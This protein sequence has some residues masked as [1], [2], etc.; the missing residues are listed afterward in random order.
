MTMAPVDA[1]T[2]QERALRQDERIVTLRLDPLREGIP[3]LNVASRLIAARSTLTVNGA[4]TVTIELFDPEWLIEESGLLDMDRHADLPAIRIHL[5]GL[6]YRLV[7]VSRRRW[8]VCELTF[9]DEVVSL[10]RRHNRPLSASRGSMTRGEFIETMVREVKARRIVFYSP[11]KGTRQPRARP[12]YPDARP[13]SGET[14]F[15]DGTTFKIKGVRADAEQMRH[16]ATSLKVAGQENAPERPVLAMLVAGIGESSFRA[17][18][19]QAGSA[20]GGVFQGDVRGGKFKLNDTEG[21]ARCFLKGG[22]GFQADGAIAA[23]RAHPDW[24]PGEIA[25]HVEGSLSNFPSLQAGIRHYQQ[26]IDEAR[27]ILSKWG[28]ADGADTDTVLRTRSYQFRRGKP[29]ERE[30]SWQAATR[31]AR[32]VRWRLFAFAGE[33]WFVSDDY[34]ISKPAALVLDGH[35]APGLLEP[36]TYDRDNGKTIQQTV[37]RV[38]ANRWS[39]RPGEVVRLEGMGPLNSR[40]IIGEVEQDLFNATETTVTLTKARAPRKEPAPALIERDVEEAAD[41]TG[42]GGGGGPIPGLAGAQRAVRWA[43]SM[44]GHYVEV[45]FTN[46]GPELDRLQSSFG[47]RAQPWCAMFATTAVQHGGVTRDCRTAAVNQVYV[48]ARAGSHGYLGLRATPKPGDLMLFNPPNPDDHIALVEKVKGDSI[49]TIEG[50]SS[51]N[52]QKVVRLTRSRSSGIFV[53]PDYPN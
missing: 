42:D 30:D 15:D 10:L 40:W 35:R 3:S 14:G 46:T 5:D 29:G 34:L 26:W 23:A 9:E 52:P 47:L 1:L 38:S 41:G 22:K 31:L 18:M 48:W 49:T 45:G 12:D 2:A 51:G 44:L 11:E 32:E 8:D 7:K 43:R 33:V 36:P 39:L 50:N 24:S 20:Y 27:T 17:V 37:L 6:A 21:M 25:L 4:S 28:G 13:S 19:N 53:R 16:V